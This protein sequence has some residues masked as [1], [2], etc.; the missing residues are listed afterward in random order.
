MSEQVTQRPTADLIM[1]EPR[2]QLLRLD[3]PL[4]RTLDLTG[5]K[6]AN[7]AASLV[8]GLPVIPGFVITTQGTSLLGG[9]DEIRDRPANDPLYRAWLTLSG[10]GSIPLAVRSSSVVEDSTTSSMAGQ[11][12]SV[13]H[14]TGWDAFADAVA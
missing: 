12:V 7:L 9:A 11:F 2:P 5:A 6:A 13:L 3:E 1:G 14:V 10:D 8:A 4:A